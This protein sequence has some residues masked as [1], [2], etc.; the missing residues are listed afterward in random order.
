MRE[1]SGS[2]KCG[3]F[4][5]GQ[6]YW[7]TKC[8][9]QGDVWCHYVSWLLFCGV[10]G[11]VMTHVYHSRSSV[12]PSV[13]PSINIYF[14]WCNISLHSGGIFM[15]LSTNITLWVGIAE[16]VFKK[17]IKTKFTFLW[18]RIFWQCDIAASLFCFLSEH[19]YFDIFS[20]LFS[21]YCCRYYSSE[22]QHDN[23]HSHKTT[24]CYLEQV[25]ASLCTIF[26]VRLCIVIL[27]SNDWCW[28]ISTQKC[29]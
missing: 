29:L 8:G 24:E 5:V 9:M 2:L 12:Q 22:E 15:K 25:T 4:G 17:V 26:Q 14:V 3:E 19:F 1:K 23:G 11:V 13:R 7:V 20:L 28:S 10:V 21:A 16:N 6:K 27:C 18:R